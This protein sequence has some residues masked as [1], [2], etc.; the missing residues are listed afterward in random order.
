VHGGSVVN[1]PWFIVNP[2]WATV[3]LVGCT[4]RRKVH[5]SAKLHR[6]ERRGGL[7]KHVRGVSQLFPAARTR[8][9]VVLAQRS[10]VLS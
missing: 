7:G 1:G 6:P 3:A 8:H 2:P 9:A 10:G 4:G 5:V